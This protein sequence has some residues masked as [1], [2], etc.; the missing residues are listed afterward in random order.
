MQNANIY[1]SQSI[2]YAASIMTMI[3]TNEHY[4]ADEKS[5]GSRFIRD[6]VSDSAH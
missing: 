4:F 1:R 2:A 3:M 6:N 5:I